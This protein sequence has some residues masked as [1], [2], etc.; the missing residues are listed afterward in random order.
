M[1]KDSKKKLVRDH[2]KK[3]NAS[4][5][6]KSP[7]R[8]SNSDKKEKSEKTKKNIKHE[9]EVKEQEGSPEK[10]KEKTKKKTKKP[11]SETNGHDEE[12]NIHEIQ[13]KPG[14]KHPEPSLDDPTR[15]F[16][17]TLYEQNPNSPMAK[18]Y[19]LEYGLLPEDVASALV[20]KL[21]NKNK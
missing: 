8:E 14:Q 9:D 1:G 7:K 11:S 15:A 3:S 2:H 17:E 16:Y 18:K 10:N 21:K 20:S 6:K 19:C 12:E 5:K 4:P 13:K